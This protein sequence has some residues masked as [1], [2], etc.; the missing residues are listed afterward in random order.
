MNKPSVL[1]ICF[2][3]RVGSDYPT[4]DIR[5][6]F[7]GPSVVEIVSTGTIVTATV[8]NNMNVIISSTPAAA[9]AESHDDDNLHGLSVT[10]VIKDGG[11]ST[12]Y[13]SIT[14]DNA[15]KHQ[16]RNQNNNKHNDV[17]ITPLDERYL[18]CAPKPD[19]K[20][21]ANPED[22]I[23]TKQAPG[24]ID[25][26]KEKPVITVN[27]PSAIKIEFMPVSPMPP[28]VANDVCVN[29]GHAVTQKAAPV[30]HDKQMMVIG[31]RHR[32]LP[33]PISD[34]AE[35]SVKASPS[36]DSKL[37]EQSIDSSDDDH[38]ELEVKEDSKEEKQ[39]HLLKEKDE[40]PKRQITLLP[41]ALRVAILGDEGSQHDLFM[42]KLEFE[43]DAEST[44]AKRNGTTP[45]S[46]NGA[47]TNNNNGGGETTV[48]PR[49]I[50][51]NKVNYQVR[52][53]NYLV[54]MNVC[55]V[56][57]F[58][59]T[60]KASQSNQFL[61]SWIRHAHLIVVMIDPRKKEPTVG[62]QSFLATHADL[63]RG[64]VP[65][66]WSQLYDRQ[67][68]AALDLKHATHKGNEAVLS[69]VRVVNHNNNNNN[70]TDNPT[71]LP[72]ATVGLPEINA[73]PPSSISP[74]IHN[75]ATAAMVTHPPPLSLTF[76]NP[77]VALIQTQEVKSETQDQIPKIISRPTS[78]IASTDTLKNAFN[79]SPGRIQRL[80]IMNDT[81]FD[82]SIMV[83]ASSTQTVK[84]PLWAVLQAHKLD[85]DV[86]TANVQ[87]D[88]TETLRFTL[89]GFVTCSRQE[90]A[91]LSMSGNR[92]FTNDEA[93]QILMS[94]ASTP[95]SRSC[96]IL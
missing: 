71:E 31:N 36:G 33:S 62:M 9:S 78:V 81:S 75:N 48:R 32:S 17:L 65:M 92:H 14:F 44:S 74:G 51:L 45:N 21:S 30:D 88:S 46:S 95:S 53:D 61:Q 41:I 66:A 39:Q 93:R 52:V 60:T 96:V 8:K 23:K 6:S 38:D 77:R 28:P 87:K 7:S 83:P 3:Q 4:I 5:E 15:G 50:G 91:L 67:I 64:A 27:A 89:S 20:E 1:W 73:L 35:K 47:T 68:S 57:D 79:V 37:R 43:T 49:F 72:T 70:N 84:A 42:R 34:R 82:D 19:A 29:C 22:A 18:D 26:N 54:D 13:H 11:H 10:P 12:S 24:D 63:M 86:F 16:P 90:P 94:S 25:N 56:S 55:D 59:N 80:V 58:I 69:S 2:N 40:E 85:C 76:K